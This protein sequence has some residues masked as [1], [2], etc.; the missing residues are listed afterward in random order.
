MTSV[1]SASEAARAFAR[2]ASS[3]RPAPESRRPKIV[4]SAAATRRS[5]S[6]RSRV[7]RISASVSR[8]YTWLRTAAPP[9]TSAV[10]ATAFAIAAGSTWALP[11]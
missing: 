4:A 6:G 10:P 1:A 5:G 2:A 7:R 8:S 3:A 9:A 11:R